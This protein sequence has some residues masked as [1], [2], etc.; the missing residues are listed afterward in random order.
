ML[1]SPQIPPEAPFC[2]ACISK[3]SEP[4]STLTFLLK[5]SSAELMIPDESLTPHIGICEA[6]ELERVTTVAGML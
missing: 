3:L 4:T 6:T 2:K 1:P 5:K